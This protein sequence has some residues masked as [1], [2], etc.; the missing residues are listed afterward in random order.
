MKLYI[1]INTPPLSG[2][3]TVDPAG[4]IAKKTIDHRNL[5]PVCET[6]EC[7][8]IYAPYILNH[9]HFTDLDRVLTH[10]ITKLRHGGVLR[11]GGTDV[12]DVAK[13]IIKDE[14]TIQQA[15]DLMYGANSFNWVNHCGAY[16]MHD[17]VDFLR[18]KNLKVTAQKSDDINFIVEAVRE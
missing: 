16:A 2:Y 4:G 5:D 3:T 10:Y 7:T 1:N 11:I 9:I 17:I 15:N 14:L 13:K 8:E 18:S 6:N 12:R